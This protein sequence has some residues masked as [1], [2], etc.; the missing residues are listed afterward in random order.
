ME[1]CRRTSSRQEG[2]PTAAAAHDHL[3]TQ[4][5]ATLE[6]REGARSSQGAATSPPRASITSTCTFSSSHWYHKGFPTQLCPTMIVCSDLEFPTHLPII[7]V[8]MR[9]WL[10][11]TNDHV[12]FPP[13]CRC[14]SWSWRTQRTPRQRWPAQGRV[15]V[16][17]L[18]MLLH[19]NIRWALVNG[20]GWL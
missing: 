2:V 3:P 5:G 12:I 4:L 13:S 7:E 8:T 18:R 20:G 10:A 14:R 19:N 9:I 16:M 1:D 15:M 11:L 6:G 17:G